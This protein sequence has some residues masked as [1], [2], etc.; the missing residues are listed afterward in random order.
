MGNAVV[1]VD[2]PVLD[3]DRAIAFYSAILGTQ[4]VKADYGTFALGFLPGEP[5]TGDVCGC[6]YV[7]DDSAPADQGPLVYLNALSRLDEAE[8]AIVPA[9]GTIMQ[10]KHQIGPHGYRVIFKDTEGNRLAL[11]SM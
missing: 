7:A 1:W 8:A 2:I 5:Q 10:P 6:L 3:L 4:L 11:H 9:G